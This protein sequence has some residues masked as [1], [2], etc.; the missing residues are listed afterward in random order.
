MIPTAYNQITCESPNIIHNKA[1]EII[2]KSLPGDQ[3]SFI[4]IQIIVIE[5]GIAPLDAV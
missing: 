4:Q 2:K 1:K 3:F 5:N